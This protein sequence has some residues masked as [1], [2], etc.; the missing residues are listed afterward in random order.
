MKRLR[1][2]LLALLILLVFV[3]PG[4]GCSF[5]DEDDPSTQHSDPDAPYSSFVRGRIGVLQPGYRIRHL[6]VA[7]NTLSGRGLTPAEQAAAIDVD[8]FYN[9]GASYTPSSDA[10]RTDEGDTFGPGLGAWQKVAGDTGLRTRDRQVPG[11]PYVI[12]TN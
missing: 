12:F 4:N 9:M 5:S 2:A 11:Q 10:V 7:Y 3:R 1:H 8:R 6:V